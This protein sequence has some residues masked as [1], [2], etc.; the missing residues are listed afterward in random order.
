MIAAAALA[1]ALSACSGADDGPVPSAAPTPS[2][3]P[4][5]A[6]SASCEG[7]PPAS[8]ERTMK[9]GDTERTY[10]V[11]VP[12]GY[13]GQEPLPVVYLFHGLGSSGPQVLGYSAF[14]TAAD[15]HQFL[16]VVP[17]GLGDVPQWD[18]VS[19]P[20]Q[21]GSDADF[22]MDVTDA[23][24]DE[25]CVDADRQYAAGMSNGSAVVFA[26][27]CSGEFPMQAY[28][29]VSA[30]FFEPARCDDAPPASILYF[31]GTDDRVVPFDGGSTPLFPVRAVDA[32][33]GDWAAHDGCAARPQEQEVGDDVEHRTWTGCDD[34]RLEAYIVEG[35]GHTWPGGIPLPTLGATT[36]TI[37]ATD[38][39]VDFFGLSD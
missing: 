35:G 23:V 18:V 13:D 21:D 19:P 8:G 2:A 11:Y 28:G 39:M 14:G 32:V 1:L 36:S 17:Q 33:L 7:P 20:E 10:G 34:A 4:S 38:L 16:V 37:S 29:G 30:T 12:Q 25:W 5:S 27:A 6:G 3:T 15:E 24:A 31:H 26:M 22:W 9:V